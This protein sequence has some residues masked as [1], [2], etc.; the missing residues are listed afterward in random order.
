MTP[1]FIAT[2]QFTPERGER[3]DG[4]I[5]WSGLT[6]LHEVVSLDGMLCPPLLG[7]NGGVKDDYWP[8]IVK[9]DFML[10]FFVAYE[11]LKQEVA[12]IQRKLNVLCV[13]RNPEAQP[14][15]PSPDFEFLGYDLVDVHG[16]NSALTNYGGFPDV[17]A[18]FRAFSCRIGTRF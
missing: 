14:V 18:K 3:W 1:W 6:Q 5:R 15:P 2:E 7:G 13:F 11:F 9:E 16:F 17:F 8:H 10:D 4:Y 12:G